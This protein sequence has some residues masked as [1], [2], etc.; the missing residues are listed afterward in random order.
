[1]T[2]MT[3]ELLQAFHTL[4]NEVD[5]LYQAYYEAQIHRLKRYLLLNHT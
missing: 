5:V 1:M 2:A 4:E 3:C